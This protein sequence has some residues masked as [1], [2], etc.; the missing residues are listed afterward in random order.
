MEEKN[1][2]WDNSQSKYENNNK[3]SLPIFYD[4]YDLSNDFKN[5]YEPAE[6]T[7]LL[8]DSI[9]NDLI[10]EKEKNK[11]LN[12]IKSIEIGCGNGLVSCCYLDILK[13]ENFKLEKHFCIDINKDALNL[14]EKLIKNYNL[15]DKVYFI[16]SDLFSNFKNN[17]KFD[18]IIFNPPYVTTDDDEYKRALEKKDIYASWAGGK[19]GSETIFKFISQLK[20]FIKDDSIIY[21]LLSKENEFF[22][23]IDDINNCINFQFEILMKIKATNEKLAV[24]KFFK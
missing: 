15:N 6:D 16:E 22:K 19:K 17:E 12:P 9:T 24:F 8:I 21:L 4:F 2:S 20:D 5:V 23:I 7:F 18:I 1:F 11:L 13:K 3:K 14:T 10:N